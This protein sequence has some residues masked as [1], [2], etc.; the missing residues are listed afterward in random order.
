MD[1]KH[2]RIDHNDNE[3]L[4]ITATQVRQQWFSVGIFPLGPE[5]S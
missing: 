4:P 3:G 2:N 5:C 1:F